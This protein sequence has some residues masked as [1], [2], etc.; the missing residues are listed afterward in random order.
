M[1]FG[2]IRQDFLYVK[3]MN[4]TLRKPTGVGMSN[5]FLIVNSENAELSVKRCFNR[6]LCDKYTIHLPVNI[7]NLYQ[8]M[9]MQWQFWLNDVCKIFYLDHIRHCDCEIEYSKYLKRFLAC[10]GHCY[11]WLLRQQKNESRRS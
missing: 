9:H 6:T 3:N 11:L 2:D 5:L 4:K 1:D 7:R 8:M 10:S